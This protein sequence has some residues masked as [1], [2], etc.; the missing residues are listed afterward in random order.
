VQDE[1]AGGYF[2]SKQLA[3]IFPFPQSGYYKFQQLL[4]SF[5][6]VHLR[7]NDIAVAETYDCGTSSTPSKD[8]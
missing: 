7:T 3:K 6:E 1:I 5:E 2:T 4:P 8:N